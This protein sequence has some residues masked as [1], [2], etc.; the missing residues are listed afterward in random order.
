MG[1]QFRM[2]ELA[3]KSSIELFNAPFWDEVQFSCINCGTCTFLCPT[4]WCFDI[5][6]EVCEEQG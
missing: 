4:C 3:G 6:D 1:I 5:Q 2:E